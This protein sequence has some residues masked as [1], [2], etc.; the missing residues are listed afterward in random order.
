MRPATRP[1][2]SSTQ[3]P[4]ELTRARALTLLAV[5]VGPFMD[6]V[7]S[8]SS[9]RRAEVAAV[10]VRMV[11]PR[12][13]ASSAFSTTRRASSTQQ[14]RIFEGRRVV[15]LDGAA[16][17]R[18]AQVELARARQHLAAAEVVVEEEAGPHHPG[19][20]LLG[21]VRQHEAHGPDD[22]GRGAQQHLALDQ[23]L[24]H[25]AELVIFE[26]AQPAVHE[27]AR[28]GG[29]A[30]GEVALLAEQHREAPPRRVA[31]D[32]GAVDAA[33]DDREVDR[34]V[35][36]HSGLSVVCGMGRRQARRRAG[37]GV[38]GVAH[39]VPDGGAAVRAAT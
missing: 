11:A 7:Q 25:Q 13:L 2:T 5:A 26:V 10:R 33:A 3:G 35:I 21:R 29:R 32:A 18:R 39:G 23:R 19:R 37:A 38:A 24:A 36:R 9:P 30:L 28:A 22:V 27:L 34:S 15:G 31:R 20:A 4:A 16:L 12:C 6:S 1:T 8:P 17:G 14:S